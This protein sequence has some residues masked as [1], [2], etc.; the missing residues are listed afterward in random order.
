MNTIYLMVITTL[1][2]FITGCSDEIEVKEY[3]YQYNPTEDSVVASIGGDKIYRSELDHLLAFHSSDPSSS[4]ESGKKAIVEAL[5]TDQVMYKKAIENGFNNNPEFIINQRKLLAFEYR[6]YL[7]EKVAKNTQISVL[8]IELYY[9]ENI[10]KYTKPGMFRLAVYFRKNN[11]GKKYDLSL[12][13]IKDAASYLRASEGFGKYSQTSDLLA[14][15]YRGGNLAW[16]AKST[17]ISG[18]PQTL[19]S[20]V[21]ALDLGQVSE[22]IEIEEGSY[23]IRLID[24]RAESI[25]PLASVKEEIRQQLLK[26]EKETNLAAYLSKAKSSFEITI[27]EQLLKTSKA[28]LAT[29][30][31]FGP[32]GFP[33]E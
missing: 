15:Q 9:Q 11:T 19:F 27:D 30:H 17:K 12:K 21:E 22:A 23:L 14:Y 7:A 25:T 10:E 13:Q 1:L 18:I 33:V 16:M 20:G 4:S 8:D 2:L 24:K 31:S 28:K 26:K 5:I 3:P 29:E 6:K 32:P